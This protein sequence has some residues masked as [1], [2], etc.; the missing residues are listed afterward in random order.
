MEVPIPVSGK[1][2]ELDANTYGK[3]TKSGMHFVK[4]FAPWCGHCQRLAPV[5]DELAKSLEYEK[6]VNIAK[7]DC[8]VSPAICE[9]VNVKGY[10]TLLWIKDGVVV[11]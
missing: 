8:T 1:P 9:S 3:V 7:V 4:F 2:L 11:S 6:S 5:W 10:P